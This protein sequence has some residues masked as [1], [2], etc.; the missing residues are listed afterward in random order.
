MNSGWDEESVERDIRQNIDFE[1][2]GREAEVRIAYHKAAA[3]IA[4]RH[5]QDVADLLASLVDLR[6]RVGKALEAAMD[7]IH[8]G[9][10]HKQWVLD[11]MVR[12]LAGDGYEEWLRDLGD[13]WEE[14]IPP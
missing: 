12:V 13:E 2:T 1:P 11:Q 4:A 3:V 8:D 10:H 5:E 14:G 9:G 7:G 6:A